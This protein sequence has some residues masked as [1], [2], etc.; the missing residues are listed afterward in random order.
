MPNKK[1]LDAVI[2]TGGQGLRT[3]AFDI[4]DACITMKKKGLRS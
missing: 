2:S 1:K 4:I 3:N